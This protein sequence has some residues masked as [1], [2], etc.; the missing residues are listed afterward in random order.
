MFSTVAVY[1]NNT[2]KSVAFLYTNHEQSENR[3]NNTIHNTSKIT[4]LGIN[5]MKE[6]KDQYNEN[7]KLVKKSMKKHN[8]Y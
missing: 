6:V 2:Q 7:Y 8:S 3:E 4:L 5:L 1:K